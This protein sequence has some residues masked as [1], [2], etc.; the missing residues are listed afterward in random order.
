MMRALDAKREGY[1][2]CLGT[3]DRRD[4]QQADPCGVLIAMPSE[5]PAAA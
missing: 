4:P 2:A 1:V 3:P 5:N